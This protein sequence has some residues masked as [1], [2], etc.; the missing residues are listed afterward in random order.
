[1]KTRRAFTLIELL[2]VIAIIAILAAMLLPALS[3]AKLK[4]QKIAC[5]NNIKQLGLAWIMYNGENNGR[6]PTCQPFDP[7]TF[8]INSNAWVRGV[9]AILSPPGAFGQV[10]AGVL[11]CTNK[12]GPALGSLYPYVSATS[13]YRCPSD[14]RTFNGVPYVRS[15]S[16]NNWMNGEPFADSA[17]NLDL[18][19]RL[20]KTDSSISTPSQLYVFMDEDA[21]TINDGMFVV[22]MNPSSGLQ[23]QPSLRHK[24]GYPLTF[25]DGHAEIF[26]FYGNGQDL[27][28]LENA[29]TVAQ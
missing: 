16:M 14:L 15:Y 2:V 3:G 5:M 19:H 24:T 22:Y 8:T 17:N 6:I 21:S 9:A 13:I 25:A 12:N 4:A 18:S 1:M 26:R 11:D 10:D 28:K 29:A 7:V 23:D 27:A 20:F